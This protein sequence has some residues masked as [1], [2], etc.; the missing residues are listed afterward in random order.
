MNSMSDNENPLKRIGAQRKRRFNMLEHVFVS[1]RRIHSTGFVRWR[2]P[3]AIQAAHLWTG[4]TTM[5]GGFVTVDGTVFRYLI[6]EWFSMLSVGQ[7]R[8]FHIHLSLA[9]SLQ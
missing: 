9:F 5:M 3:S 7:N 2:D 8:H 4:T 6:F 1:S